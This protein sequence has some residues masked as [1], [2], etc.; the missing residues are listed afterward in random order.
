MGARTYFFYV[1]QL[2]TL[3]R[4]KQDRGSG[5]C[6]VY[7]YIYIHIHT[8][9][10]IYD[11]IQEKQHS[12]TKTRMSLKRPF[13]CQNVS[14]MAHGHDY[15][16]A[17]P[18]GKLIQLAIEAQGSPITLHLDQH[19]K[20]ATSV[21]LVCAIIPTSLN[22]INS[23]N[24]NFYFTEMYSATYTPTLFR[25][26]IAPGM[27]S[28][29]E[30]AAAVQAAIPS[31]VAVPAT[32]LYNGLSPNTGR[33]LGTYT[34]A[35]DSATSIIAVRAAA[36][37]L[38]GMVVHAASAFADLSTSA[39]VHVI[40]T[41][42]TL[43][44]SAR[45]VTLT[46][47]ASSAGTTTFVAVTGSAH[48]IGAHAVVSL[49]FTNGAKSVAVLDYQ[50]TTPP[51]ATTLT[52]LVADADVVGI[53]PTDPLTVTSIIVASDAAS[54]STALG[55]VRSRDPASVAA[56]NQATPL[57]ILSH[58][59]TASLNQ[60]VYSL[61]AAHFMVAGDVA[62]LSSGDVVT[63]DVVNS[64][65]TVTATGALTATPTT[66]R[67]RAALGLYDALVRSSDKADLSL[68]TR[69]TYIEM[70]LGNTT[71]GNIHSMR[72]RGRRYV[73]K[74]LMNAASDAVVFE[75]HPLMR[76]TLPLVHST[77][78][79]QTVTL[80]LYDAQERAIDLPAMA[81]SCMVEIEAHT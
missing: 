35:A 43:A 26:G 53:A 51:T 62:T 36:T 40:S 65:T 73:G 56:G 7:T 22:A 45:R 23:S 55:F 32:A 47:G 12:K 79:F 50:L 20:M 9:I 19:Y 39:A 54:I 29:D 67:L 48:N 44:A 57:N 81:W 5:C 31:A 49:R 75:D 10:Y 30:L 21:R 8:H 14:D 13:H 3:I 38:R 28:I 69:S 11:P 63:V 17:A 15:A 2:H 37:T 66:M 59:A 41:S 80:R 64:S 72:H 58:N 34:V 16:P 61:D 52:F 6:I 78:T 25:A 46:M 1:S 24:N 70:L 27:Y 42:Q 71:V 74:V 60:R 33:P 76:A 77:N 68:A 18:K 4:P